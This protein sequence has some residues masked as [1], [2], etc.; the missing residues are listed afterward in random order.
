[1]LLAV[2]LYGYCTGI[3]SS[4][5]LERRCREDIAFRVLSGN[6]T[7]DHVTIA[8]FRARHEQALAGL[9]IASLKLCAAVGMIRLGTVALEAPSWPPTPPSEPTAPTPTSRPRSPSCSPRQRPPT[10]PRTATTAPPTLQRVGP[11]VHLDATTGSSAHPSGR[12][13][14]PLRNGLL[15][16]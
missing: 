14:T 8:R 1:M 4:R 10:R 2:M 13:T 15:S 6:T 16:C 9:L 5:Q 11:I 7:P 12:H 3:R